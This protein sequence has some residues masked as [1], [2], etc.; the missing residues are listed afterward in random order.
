MLQE[1][2]SQE[3]RPPHTGRQSQGGRQ[4]SAHAATLDRSAPGKLGFAAPSISLPKGQGSI[5]GI[6]ERF[7]P[8]LVKDTGSMTVPIITGLGGSYSGP[9]HSRYFDTGDRS[10][11]SGWLL[12]M[13]IFT[14]K[15]TKGLPQCTEVLHSVRTWRKKK[16]R[17]RVLAVDP[18]YCVAWVAH[19]SSTAVS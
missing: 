1:Q 14:Y 8:N 11:G 10:R 18:C 3:R 5:R 13:S 7:A 2:H 15:M 19:L 12:S 16:P 6:G 9:R 17:N 4:S